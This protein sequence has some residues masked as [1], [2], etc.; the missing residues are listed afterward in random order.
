[1]SEQTT[2]QTTEQ[3]SSVLPRILIGAAIGAVALIVYNRRVI[4]AAVSGS[5]PEAPRPGAPLP[6]GGRVVNADGTPVPQSE[7]IQFDHSGTGTAG[8][9]GGGLGATVGA[10]VAHASSTAVQTAQGAFSKLMAPIQRYIDSAKAQLDVAIAEG[11]AQA[12]RT[13][14]DLE[15][16]FEESKKDPS[17]GRSAFM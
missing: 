1:M 12:Q 7:T 3:Q 9:S 11:Q 8:G 4:L 16:R 10:S 15:A 5:G 17:R 13:R 14:V 2:E 6:P